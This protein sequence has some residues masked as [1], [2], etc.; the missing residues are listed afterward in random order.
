MLHVVIL[1]V[2]LNGI[3]PTC[4]AET[5]SSGRAVAETPATSTPP[6]STPATPA[7][8]VDSQAVTTSSKPADPYALEPCS[9][10]STP[11]PP[12]GLL[13]TFTSAYIDKL[14]DLV[15]SLPA[16]TSCVPGRVVIT[17][18]PGS[19]LLAVD[20]KDRV[21]FLHCASEILLGTRRH[22]LL[23]LSLLRSIPTSRRWACLSLLRCGRELR[24]MIMTSSYQDRVIPA[25]FAPVC[26][27]T[28]V[29]VMF[30]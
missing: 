17:P 16:L 21:R 20:V 27:G 7:T 2:I 14:G 12:V 15:L 5:P 30:P 23:L 29:N 8:P 6:I 19:P 11:F 13:P 10:P 22:V 4:G 28:G 26:T 24:W 18:P 25:Q 1:Q 3:F 9:G